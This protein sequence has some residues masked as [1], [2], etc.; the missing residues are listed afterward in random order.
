MIGLLDSVVRIRVS[1]RRRRPKG[2]LSEQFS[3]Y[4]FN[5]QLVLDRLQ[6]IKSLLHGVNLLVGHDLLF[7]VGIG[8]QSETS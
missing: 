3:R 8:Q 1:G 4:C 6:A 2:D 5:S 7:H